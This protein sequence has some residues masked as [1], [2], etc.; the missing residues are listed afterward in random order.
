[1]VRRWQA[2]LV[3]YPAGIS[4]GL[5]VGNLS[6]AGAESGLDEEPRSGIGIGVVV[7]PRG[8][9]RRRGE[10]LGTV[11]G[12]EVAANLTSGVVNGVDVEIGSALLD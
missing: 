10:G 9:R 8:R 4:H 3:A 2:K 6:W 1:M 11:H 5:H 7:S 12:G